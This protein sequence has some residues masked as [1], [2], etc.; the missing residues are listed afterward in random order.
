MV[1]NDAHAHIRLLVAR[2][3]P[4]PRQLLRARDDGEDLIGLI[5]VVLALQKIGET[6][7]AETGIDRLAVEFT[8]QRVI[9]PAAL[10]SHVLVKDKVPDLEVAIAARVDA[11]SFGLGA[12][13]GATIVMP[14]STW[15]GR[16]RLAGRPEVFFLRKA[17]NVARIDADH[18][19]EVVV[20]FLIVLPQGDPQPIAL[21]SVPAFTH[22]RREKLPREVDRAFLEVIPKAEVAG[23]LEERAVTRGLA[24]IVDVVR[25][26][27]LLDARRTWPR[28]RIRANNVG[29]ER[30]HAGNGEKDR[31]IRGD[32]RVARDN[33]VV[34]ALEEFEPPA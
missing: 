33:L 19:R 29:N 16:T 7:N 23:H 13:L 2:P 20:G 18:A 4:K 14:F 3:V 1:G 22:T 8:D 21:Q 34:L 24:D 11:A 12:E 31:R 27:A 30:H 15:A 32:E 6:L 26:D 5:H 10:A 17:H 25:S 28:S 9:L